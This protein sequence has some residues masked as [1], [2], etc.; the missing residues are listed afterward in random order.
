MEE[1]IGNVSMSIQGM[2]KGKNWLLLVDRAYT[3]KLQILPIW[4]FHLISTERP[5]LAEGRGSG[6]IK[7]ADC[8]NLASSSKEMGSF[9]PLVCVCDMHC[10]GCNALLRT[11]SSTLSALSIPAT[12]ILKHSWKVCPFLILLEMIGK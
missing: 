8:R 7:R 9:Y 1:G 4:E 6:L 10:H 12:R 2:E 5:N 3:A 11:W